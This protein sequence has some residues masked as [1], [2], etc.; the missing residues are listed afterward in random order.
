MTSELLDNLSKILVEI[1]AIGE[2]SGFKV[3]V[4]NVRCDDLLT[5]E[6]FAQVEV[7]I[8]KPNQIPN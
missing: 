8:S 3:R 1:Q 5:V 7:Y 2:R 6:E 4:G